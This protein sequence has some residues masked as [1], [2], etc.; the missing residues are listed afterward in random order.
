MITCTSNETT[1]SNEASGNGSAVQEPSRLDMGGGV[2]AL[3]SFG[4][5]EAGELY[6]ISFGSGAQVRRIVAR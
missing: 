4:E 1:R 2:G 6:V 5:D 3:V